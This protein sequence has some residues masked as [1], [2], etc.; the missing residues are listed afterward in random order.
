MTTLDVARLAPVTSVAGASLSPRW[1]SHPVVVAE[2]AHDGWDASHVWADD[3]ALLVRLRWRVRTDGLR[4]FAVEHDDDAASVLG[5]GEP[6][7]AARLVVAAGTALG[8]V[9]RV[10]APR[11]THAELAGLAA[12]GH[13]VPA[14]FDRLPVSAWDW[15]GTTTSPA[16]QPGEDRVVE[17]DATHRH[18]AAACLA[19]ANPHGELSLDEPRSRWWG[20]LDDDGTVRGV[21]GASRRVPGQPWVLGSVGTDPAFRGRGIAAAVT[22]AATRAG[23]AE[24]AMVTLGMYAH[25]DAARRVYERLGF[26]R[27]QEFES[28]R[29]ER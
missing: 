22:A 21:A 18:G 14:P 2:Q 7:A 25:N 27:V 24:V 1:A 10:S 20:W 4:P 29:P 16:V 19:V 26:A 15:Y 8:T 28:W 13:R 3:D 17:L 6:G 11:G 5:L 9:T 12:A 23:L